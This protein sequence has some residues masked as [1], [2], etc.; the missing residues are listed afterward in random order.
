MTSLLNMTSIPFVMTN[1]APSTS[2]KMAPIKPTWSVRVN[3]RIVIF[4]AIEKPTFCST[5]TR[6]DLA[7]RTA[8]VSFSI[9]FEKMI[10]SAVSIATGVPATPIAIPTSHAARAGASLTP[11]PTIPTVPRR[12]L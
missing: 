12:R 4:S 3:A 5:L 7:S 10:T 11:S 2:D 8:S 6:Q 9:L 1:M